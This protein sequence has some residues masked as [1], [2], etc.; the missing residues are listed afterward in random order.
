GVVRF[1]LA[2]KTTMI[3]HI[4][5]GA[6]AIYLLARSWKLRATPA[7][8]GAL[9]YALGGYLLDHLR[10]GHLSFVNPLAWLP[11]AFFLFDRALHARSRAW[12]SA[13]LAGAAMGLGVLEGG[14]TPI[15]YG[16]LGLALAAP[17]ML[18]ARH[19]WRDRWRDVARSIGLGGIAAV[20]ALCVCGFQLLPMLSYMARTNR[21]G[22][23]TFEQSLSKISEV[24]HPMPPTPA[25]VVMVFGFGF[26]WRS[27]R[28]AIAVWLV[29]A[30][31]LGHFAATSDKLFHALW[32][33]APGFR[34]QRIPGRAYSLVAVAAPPL[35]AAGLQ[36][37]FELL[38]RWGGV[39][40]A[41]AWGLGAWIV[42]AFAQEAPDSP[43]MSSP[44]IEL[45]ANHTMQWLSDHAGGARVH[46][47]ESP[48]RHWGCE[49][50]TVRRGLEVLASYTP[51]DHRD[52]MPGD[53]D[54]PGYRTFLSESER[55]P[56]R[57]WGVMNARYV[58][59][60]TPRTEAGFHLATR[61][62]NCPLEICQPAK[63]AG[64]YIYENE[65]WLP[66]AYDVQQ[67]VALR[68]E[69]R[70]TFE[71]ALDL[72]G[73][74]AFDLR[75]A[76]VVQLTSDDPTPANALVFSVGRDTPGLL[77]WDTAEARSAWRSAM[78]TLHE[79]SGALPQVT[80]GDGRIELTPAI[81]GWIVLSERASLFPG[82]SAAS[83]EGG[84][85]IWRADGVVTALQGKAGQRIT[86]RYVPQR[87]WIGVAM[88]VAWLAAMIA[89]VV[90]TSRLQSR[91]PSCDSKNV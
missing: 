46:I 78:T 30:C 80:I 13:A 49:N 37:A 73:D 48:N 55:S 74:A 2:A 23:L 57:F 15:V 4:A 84:L 91:T 45:A 90:T 11:W 61:V 31:A 21:A 34:Y 63:S 10:V 88:L 41:I 53:F 75:R 32:K 24:A 66:R 22:G 65:R 1:E 50:I 79:P 70:A 3:L 44:K 85:K 59:S 38:R 5:I 69:P 14:T 25:L 39:G 33:W 77:R 36:G 40:R 8:I 47:W 60:S 81:D 12:L 20:S 56:A 16:A 52:Y 43:P 54:P 62:E 51:S 68:G 64:T 67:I 28:R 71:A 82:W 87:F 35:I 76:A 17:A 18:F 86:L 42:Y 29:A 89:A 72:V 6:A 26:L 58:V 27:G 19:S 9:S 83:A 7:A